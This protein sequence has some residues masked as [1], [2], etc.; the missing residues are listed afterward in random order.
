MV[1]INELYIPQNGNSIVLKAEVKSEAYYQNVY[2]DKVYV[3]T[4]DTYTGDFSK[5]VYTYTC[6][7]NTKNI[8]LEITALQMLKP[9]KDN[10]FIVSVVTKGTPAS[11]T[12]CGMD[13]DTVTSVA[14]DTCGVYNTLLEAMEG[15]DENCEVPAVAMDALLQYTMFVLAVD[16]GHIDT[17]I[18]TYNKFF[19]KNVKV[20]TRKCKCN[21]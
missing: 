20:V 18:S 14:F 3:D 15:F 2:I 11:D 7:D 1:T 9:I 13:N 21:G 6:P 8:D 17:A 12:P 5:T 19:G 16:T 4:Q 10:L